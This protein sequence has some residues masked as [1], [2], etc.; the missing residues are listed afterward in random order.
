MISKAL[1]HKIE[2]DLNYAKRGAGNLRANF[3]IPMGSW[4]ISGFSEVTVTPLGIQSLM[5]DMDVEKP[6][7]FNLDQMFGA[8]WL[9]AY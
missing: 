8:G 2:D 6:S 5:I 9:F 1:Q 7:A 3:N 4:N